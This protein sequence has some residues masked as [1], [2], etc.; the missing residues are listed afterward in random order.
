MVIVVDEKISI[1]N[2]IERLLKEIFDELNLR[3]NF[4]LE[5]LSTDIEKD[6]DYLHSSSMSGSPH[7]I[8][9][10]TELFVEVESLKKDILETKSY[11]HSDQSVAIKIISNE[12]ASTSRNG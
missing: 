3:I 6:I 5:K 8:L 1:N 9:V 2:K 10:G 4:Q 12:L 11:L 7:A